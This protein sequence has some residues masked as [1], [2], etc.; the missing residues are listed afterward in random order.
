MTPLSLKLI[1]ITRDC[2]SSFVVVCQAFTAADF[3]CC[4]FVG[5]SV[6][7]FVFSKLNACSIGLKSG[8]WHGHCRIFHFFTFKNSWVVFSVCFGSLYTRTMKCH[9]INFDAIGWIWADSIS[10]YTSEFIRLLLSSV[11]SSLNTSNPVPLEAMHTTPPCFTNYVVC[12]GSWA[13]PSLLQTFF[14]PSFCNRLILISNL[15]KIIFQKWSGF[16]RCSLAKSNLALVFRIYQTVDLATTNVPTVSL[17]DLFWFWSL[18]IVCFPCMESSSDR[19]MW[20]QSNSFQIQ[21]AHL[22][23]TPELV[24]A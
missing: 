5:P 15:P 3:S 19:M 7:S 11:T 24:P 13:V 9:A 12:F 21:M 22:E 6:F 20:V 18:K 23:T 14:F 10:L 4:L 2:V 16:F 8:D 17:M 1:D